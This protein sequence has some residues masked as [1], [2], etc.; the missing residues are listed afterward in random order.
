M[1]FIVENDTIRPVLYSELIRFFTASERSTTCSA[2]GQN[3]LGW[4]VHIDGNH[5]DRTQTTDPFLVEMVL[6]V[7]YPSSPEIT[8][9]EAKVFCIECPR[10]SHMEFINRSRVLQ[11][12]SQEAQNG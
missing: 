11:F 7:R 8:G 5:R 2:C 1:G 3:T 12:L 4:T 6:P 10:C 9:Q